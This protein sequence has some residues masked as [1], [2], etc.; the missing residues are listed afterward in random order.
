MLSK[1]SDNTSIVAFEVEPVI[2]SPLWN[3]PNPVSSKSILS[4]AS[5]DVLSNI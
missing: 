4:P 3:L 1:S 2:V 5:N